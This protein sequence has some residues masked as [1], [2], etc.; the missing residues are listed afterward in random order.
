MAAV[1]AAYRNSLLN[2]VQNAPNARNSDKNIGFPES[3]RSVGS[4]EE[5]PAYSAPS[6]LAP[7]KTTGVVADRRRNSRSKTKYAPD[8]F[9]KLD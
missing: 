6:N 2:I 3:G 9:S 5:Q 1:A 4:R 8:F 7:A